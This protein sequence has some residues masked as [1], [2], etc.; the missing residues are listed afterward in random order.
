MI[1]AEASKKLDKLMGKVDKAK[2]QKKIYLKQ[3]E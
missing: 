3:I 1:S 2:E